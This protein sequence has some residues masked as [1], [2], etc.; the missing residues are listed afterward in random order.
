MI[1]KSIKQLNRVSIRIRFSFRVSIKLSAYR[2]NKELFPDI[3]IMFLVF[4]SSACRPIT[5]CLLIR[6]EADSKLRKITRTVSGLTFRL[7]VDCSNWWHVHNEPTQ[8]QRIDLSLIH[9]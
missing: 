1:E 6:R 3:L 4:P 9:I 8:Q 7:V 5:I 2:S